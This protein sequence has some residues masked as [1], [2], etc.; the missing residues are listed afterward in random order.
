MGTGGE[1][2]GKVIFF[3]KKTQPERSSKIM[4]VG[5]E[6]NAHPRELEV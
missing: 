4:E 1:N 3:L 2:G 6:M 5:E